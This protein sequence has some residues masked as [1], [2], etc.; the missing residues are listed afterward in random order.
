M[1]HIREGI[2][3]GRGPPHLDNILMSSIFPSRCSCTRALL[4]A[5]LLT[6]LLREHDTFENRRSSLS[7]QASVFPS[8]FL[9]SP[10]SKAARRRTRLPPLSVSAPA[11]AAGRTMRAPGSR[12]AP[13]PSPF[14]PDP[15]AATRICL[16]KFLATGFSQKIFAG[17]SDPICLKITTHLGGALISSHVPKKVCGNFHQKSNRRSPQ[18]YFP[19]AEAQDAIQTPSRTRA[20]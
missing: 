3:H 8:A 1:A 6:L 17:I 10:R 20:L 11:G 19:G 2:F 7:S 13:V 5:R 4:N 16:A 14:P 15:S 18:T 12:S 9:I